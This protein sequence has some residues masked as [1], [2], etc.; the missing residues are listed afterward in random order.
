MC[1]YY[2]AF[3]DKLVMK[4]FSDYICDGE[5]FGLFRLN[6]IGT[7]PMTNKDKIRF[8]NLLKGFCKDRN[9][10][11]KE[12][13]AVDDLLK[14]IP[15]DWIKECFNFLDKNYGDAITEYVSDIGWLYLIENRKTKAYFDL[16]DKVDNAISNCPQLNTSTMVIRGIHNSGY[17]VGQ[18]ILTSTPKSASFT[19]NNC[20]KHMRNS[21]MEIYTKEGGK[22]AYHESEDQIIF[23]SGSKFQITNIKEKEWAIG[24]FTTYVAEQI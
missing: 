24:T 16:F 13:T 20:E 9:I 15:V 3:T 17:H 6:I 10:D 11:Y 23:P 22:F 4:L 18:I 19:S 5:L 12:F 8:S 7:S 14:T 1:G 21:I 2:D